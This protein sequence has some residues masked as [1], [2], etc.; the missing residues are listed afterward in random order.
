[1]GP[2][3][4][5]EMPVKQVHLMFAVTVPDGTDPQFVARELSAALDDDDGRACQW[6]SW[7]VGPPTLIGGGG[8]RG[9]GSGATGGPGSASVR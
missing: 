8:G 3:V 6:G 4:Y 7:T 9:S 2:Q 5:E 1:M